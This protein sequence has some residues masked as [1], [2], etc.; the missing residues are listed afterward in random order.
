MSGTPTEQADAAGDGPPTISEGVPNHCLTCT[1]R[2]DWGH[3]RRI[4]R[5]VTKQT[6]RLPP[7]TTIAGLLAA[8][9]GVGR[10]EY[11]DTFSPENSAIG[12]EI[13][14]SL[15]TVTEPTLGLGTNPGETFDRAGGTGRSTVQV[16]FPDSTDNRQIHSYE[17]L[18]EPAYRIHIATEDTEFYDALRTHLTEGTSH[19]T[20]T[21]G[22]SEL[23]ADVSL[24]ASTTN[25]VSPVTP[26]AADELAET[27][28]I[29]SA[30]PGAVDSVVPSPGTS[31]HVER[32]PAFM[33]ADGSYRRTTE[34]TDYAFTD[35]GPLTARATGLNDVALGRVDGRLIAFH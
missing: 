30:L 24:P 19:Y 23:L 2:G 17:Y 15:R 8:I 33:E 32:L 11:Y 9:V 27:V 14:D 20:P 1:V 21:L 34:F 4:D 35:D 18:V 31:H 7:R 13:C 16:E 6:Y 3:F 25:P 26:V 5:T 29:E 12:I 10:D 22:L 28:E